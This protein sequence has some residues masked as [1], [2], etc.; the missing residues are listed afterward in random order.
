MDNQTPRPQDACTFAAH[1]LAHRLG[2]ML[3]Y[4]DG[5]LR[6]KDPEAV[7][8]MRVWSRRARVVFELFADCFEE[9]DFKEL[10]KELRSI[11]RA[12]RE[13]RDLD[14]M[15]ERLQR[16]Q[17]SLPPAQRTGIQ[18]LCEQLVQ[19]RTQKQQEVAATLKRFEARRVKEQFEKLLAPY[20]ATIQTKTDRKRSKNGHGKNEPTPR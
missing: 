20:G 1:A 12:L 16:E 9:K 13:A 19:K 10:D 5:V 11:T 15:L 7:H 2:R 3:S 14:V 17:E 4:F 6:G 18:Q 8:Q